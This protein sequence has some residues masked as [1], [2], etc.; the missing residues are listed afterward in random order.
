M[1]EQLTVQLAS[2]E[3]DSTLSRSSLSPGVSNRKELH[4]ARPAEHKSTNT[5]SRSLLQNTQD[6]VESG[7]INSSQIVDSSANNCVVLRPSLDSAGIATNT[8]RFS[9]NELESLKERFVDFIKLDPNASSAANNLAM[10]TSF[11]KATT[12]GDG[13]L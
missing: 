6:L 7:L 3:T 12:S 4:A 2:Y 8:N 9:C 13:G 10:N 5:N 11:V 1:P